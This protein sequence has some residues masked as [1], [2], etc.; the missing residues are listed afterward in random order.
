[1]LA[2]TISIPPGLPQ[3]DYTAPASTAQIKHNLPKLPTRPNLHGRTL[4]LHSIRTPPALR[5]RALR[6]AMPLAVPIHIRLRSRPGGVVVVA[7][8]RHATMRRESGFVVMKVSGCISGEAAGRVLGLAHLQLRCGR[9]RLLCPSAFAGA[10]D[11]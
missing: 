9:A 8:Q 2:T 1:M 5:A 10:L 7:A 4:R 3:T 11:R 6:R